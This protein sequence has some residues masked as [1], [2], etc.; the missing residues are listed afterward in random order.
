MFVNTRL[1][2]SMHL[3]HYVTVRYSN[4]YFC[5]D[6]LACLRVCSLHGSS[7]SLVCRVLAFTVAVLNAFTGSS[8]SRELCCVGRSY[9]AHNA[10]LMRALMDNLRAEDS[11]SLTRENVLGCLQKLSLRYNHAS[12]A[13]FVNTMHSYNQ[14][15][16]LARMQY[17]A[18]LSR[19]H[20]VFA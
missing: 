19:C 2:S 17:F 20:Q 5:H 11:D 4:T 1:D 7:F 13:C 14:Q 9:L 18:Y 6:L 10:D 16:G 8:L 12:A 3:L 15:T